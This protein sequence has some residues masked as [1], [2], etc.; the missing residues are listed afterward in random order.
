LL[1]TVRFLPSEQV[2]PRSCQDPIVQPITT[3]PGPLARCGPVRQCAFVVAELEPAVEW[4][5]GSM[6]TRLNFSAGHKIVIVEQVVQEA[7]ALGLTDR[8]RP[9]V[10]QYLSR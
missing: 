4:W 6:A 9:F 7:N 10:N 3:R 8:L 5:T 2:L 1:L